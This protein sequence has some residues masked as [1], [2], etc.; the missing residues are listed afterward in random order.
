MAGARGSRR[1]IPPRY[2]RASESGAASSRSATA[3]PSRPLRLTAKMPGRRARGG[4]SDP[5]VVRVGGDAEAGGQPDGPSCPA[6]YGVS[7]ILAG[8]P[9]AFSAAPCRATRGRTTT[10]SSPAYA[11]AQAGG[12][13]TLADGRGDL[14]DRAAAVQMAAAV[15]HSLE[16]I[17]VDEEHR[18]G[19]AV[20]GAG[21]DERFERLVEVAGVVEAGQV[22]E[23]RELAET[24]L[25]RTERVLGPLAVG[26]SRCRSR[27]SRSSAPR[28]R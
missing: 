21:G 24:L 5:R 23:D 6:R 10:N 17:E 13:E 4:P 3:M 8:Y 27:G 15:H 1:P 20:G 26:R 18:E 9:A 22:I 2:R 16:V 7:Q 25:A 14:L 28:R 12:C 11:T 19:R